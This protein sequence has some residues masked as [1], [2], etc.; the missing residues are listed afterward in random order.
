[1]D[2]SFH[3][4]Y[5]GYYSGFTLIIFYL[6]LLLSL[7]REYINIKLT[8]R[9]SWQVKDYHPYYFYEYA[10]MQQ[11]LNVPVKLFSPKTKDGFINHF[12][13]EL[14]L[15][16]PFVVYGNVFILDWVTFSSGSELNLIMTKHIFIINSISLFFIFSLYIMVRIRW[17]KMD[18]LWSNQAIAFNFEYILESLSI[19]NKLD[20]LIFMPDQPINK[21]DLN[22][23][24]KLWYFYIDKYW[25]ANKLKRHPISF[26]TQFIDSIFN[27]DFNKVENEIYDQEK[28]DKYWDLLIGWYVKHGRKNVGS[29]FRKTFKD[30]LI[31]K[32]SELSSEIKKE[33]SNP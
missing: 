28:I 5:L 20:S 14:A 4:N 19:D 2:L 29:S 15:I 7:N 13:A 17:I 12:V 27:K 11:V 26:F 25:Y 8:F 30:M 9:K 21:E 16:F 3:I 32:P 31:D 23:I 22:L 33:D 24:K 10:T 1:M 18:K 6:L